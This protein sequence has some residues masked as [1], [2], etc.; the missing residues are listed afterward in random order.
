LLFSSLNRCWLT[1]LPSTGLVADK[2]V[3][4]LGSGTGFLGIV[5]ATLQIQ[6]RG[7]TNDTNGRLWLTDMNEEV[8]ARCHHNL[9]LPCNL[10]SLHPGLHCHK[11]D[12]FAALS[13]DEKPSLDSFLGEIDPD[14]VLGT[15]IVY[16]PSIIPSLIA[17]LRLA[18][19]P[20]HQKVPK[21]AILALTVRN[22]ATHSQFLEAANR[23]FNITELDS[24]RV[25]AS[26]L[27]RY[28][29]GQQEIQLLQLDPK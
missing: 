27:Y 26:F 15:D 24:T 3:L 14:V 9:H 17:V 7:I 25:E 20:R 5:V 28:P 16:D 29:R 21:V 19:S 6:Q 2:R 23:A 10:S 1:L 4:E 22:L 13:A 18:L 8:L 12:W 11:L